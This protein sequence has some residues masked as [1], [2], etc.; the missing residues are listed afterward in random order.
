MCFR[1]EPKSNSCGHDRD[2]VSAFYFVEI[3]QVS[4]AEHSPLKSSHPPSIE[5]PA[6]PAGRPVACVR[7]DGGLGFE[8]SNDLREGVIF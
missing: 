8:A 5:R 2:F 7:Q 4:G 3:H 6:L 1:E